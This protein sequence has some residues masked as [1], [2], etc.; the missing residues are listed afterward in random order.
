MGS[1]R[2]KQMFCADFSSDGTLLAVTAEESITLW[3]PSSNGLVH[4]LARSNVHP[5]KIV[6]FVPSTHYLVAASGSELTVWN[7]ETLSICWSYNVAVE[8]MVVHPSGPYFAISGRLRKKGKK[9]MAHTF[10]T[11]FNAQSSA[12]YAVW[13]TQDVEESTMLWLPSLDLGV[14]ASKDEEKQDCEKKHLVFLNRQREY[15]IFDPLVHEKK[16]ATASKKSFSK[17]KEEGPSAFASVYGKAINV[18]LELQSDTTKITGAQPKGKLLNGPS[19]LI[20]LRS[21]GFSYI[22]SLFERRTGVAQ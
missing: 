19:H 2:Q 6:R 13:N 1:Y 3:N 7:L 9:G 17:L 10:I 14:D 5:I 21:I 15:I 20:S 11:V 18:Q 12:P 16:S 8:A 22:E 4:V